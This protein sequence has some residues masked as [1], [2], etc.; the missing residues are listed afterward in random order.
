MHKK[1]IFAFSLLV[2][3]ANEKLFTRKLCSKTKAFSC[4]ADSVKALTQPFFS[5]CEN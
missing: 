3:W 5:F 1:G 4:Y 2:F